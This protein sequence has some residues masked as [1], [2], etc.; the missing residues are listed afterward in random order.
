MLVIPDDKVIVPS[1]LYIRLQMNFDEFLLY[2]KLNKKFLHYW[3]YAI[4][5]NVKYKVFKIKKR[6]SSEFR[7]ITAPR[8]ELLLIQNLIKNFLENYIVEHSLYMPASCVTGFVM[9][10]SIIDN[11][12]IHKNQNVIVNIDLKDFFPSI[13]FAR[14]Y[15]LLYNPPYNFD[16]QIASAIAQSTC[17]NKSLAQ[18]S[19]LSPLISNL[20]CKSLDRKLLRFAKDNHLRYS[21]YADDITFSTCNTECDKLYK[22]NSDGSINISKDISDLIAGSSFQINISKFKVLKRSTRQLVTGLVVNK[23]VNIDRRYIREIRSILHNAEKNLTTACEKYFVIYGYK[24]KRIDMLDSIEKIKLFKKILRGKIEFIRQVRGNRDII[25][26]TFFKQYFKIFYPNLKSLYYP[27]CALFAGEILHNSTLVISTDLKEDED[28]IPYVGSG[29]LINNDYFVT[30]YHTYKDIYI[31]SEREAVAFHCDDYT[32]KFN[33]KFIDGNEHFDVAIFKILYNSYKIESY[34]DLYSGQI[35]TR[36][37]VYTTGYRNG[38]EIGDSL[39][40]TEDVI[41]EI[42]LYS[43]ITNIL[44]SGHTSSG[45]SGGPVTMLCISQDEMKDVEYQVVGHIVKYITTKKYLDEYELGVSCAYDIRNT[46][47][48]IIKKYENEKI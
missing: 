27:Q 6:K 19:P 40:V 43:Y 29:Y 23:K 36:D 32:E 17:Y 8:R 1:N 48:E 11:A 47:K 3:L 37:K 5:D 45:M 33:L 30:C 13:T 9:D 44:F 28:E 10:K 7:I 16:K 34:L 35:N 31:K 15:G 39:F 46:I 18:G 25:S 24:Y 22:T 2:S 20:I 4:D 41:N 26:I 14:I 42:H 38:Y 21:R 12:F